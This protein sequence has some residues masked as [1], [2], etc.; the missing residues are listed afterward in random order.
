MALGTQFSETDYDLLMNDAP[1]I[2]SKL[3]LVDT[4]PEPATPFR[5]V[6]HIRAPVQVVVDQLVSTLTQ[7]QNNG[8]KSAAN[9]RA[10]VKKDVHYH[11][12]FREF[13]AA[14]KRCADDFVLVGDSTRPTYYAS[15]MYETEKPGRYF[16]SVSGFGTLGYAIPA[17]FGAG[18]GSHLPVIGLIGD[19]GAQFTLTELAT[20]VDNK[21]PVPVIVWQNRGYEEITNSLQA[22]Q[23]GSS[24]TDISSPDY[25]AIANAYR[26]P[27][28]QP[29][30][31][32]GLTRALR[33]ALT[34]DGPSLVLVAQDQFI[35]Q[36]SG[37]WY[38]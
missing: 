38:G 34:L 8:I 33:K 2:K 23:V 5:S 21:I 3:V 18:V 29:K 28:F 37:Q 24:S 16:H 36:P 15:W 26:I 25:K 7:R 30:T 27:C 4:D 1:Q 6:K 13:F 11:P 10:Q 31:S 9:L 22:R 14:L 12:E 17:A 35:K 20:A 32:L 19:G